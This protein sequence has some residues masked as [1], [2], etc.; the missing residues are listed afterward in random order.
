MVTVVHTIP[1][2]ETLSDRGLI[3]IAIDI[4]Q[5]DRPAANT[6]LSLVAHS[7]EASEIELATDH[8]ALIPAEEV[9]THRAPLAVYE[10]LHTSL[11]GEAPTHQTN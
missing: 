4:V 11:E 5:P 9:I 3:A 8:T 2:T 6:K 1:V 10:H 7:D